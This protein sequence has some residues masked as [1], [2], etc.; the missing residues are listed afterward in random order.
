MGIEEANAIV[1]IVNVIVHA[2][3]IV[4]TA[5]YIL[6][7]VFVMTGLSKKSDNNPILMRIGLLVTICYMLYAFYNVINAFYI[8]FG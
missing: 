8:V 6:S 3:V 5:M 7:L 1:H 2:V 4:T